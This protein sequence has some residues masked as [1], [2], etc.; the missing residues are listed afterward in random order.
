[1]VFFKQEKVRLGLCLRTQIRVLLHALQVI[2]FMPAEYAVMV[3]MLCLSFHTLLIIAYNAVNSRGDNEAQ[4]H[5]SAEL[6]RSNAF[7]FC[8][9]G[10]YLYVCGDLG[11]CNH[12]LLIFT[13]PRSETCWT[14]EMCN[15]LKVIEY[16]LSSL[17]EMHKERGKGRKLCM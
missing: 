14:V 17:W 15:F 1:M 7:L 2:V 6:W 10:P 12:V 13:E 11:S 9:T 4:N 3:A 16:Y 8:T 5:A